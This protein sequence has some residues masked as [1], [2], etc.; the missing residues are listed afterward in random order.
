M[1]NNKVN[2]AV[3]D[4][5][6]SM[7]GQAAAR[8]QN[9]PRF[10]EVV[11]TAKRGVANWNDQDKELLMLLQDVPKLTGVWPYVCAVLNFVI[12][13]AGTMLSSCVETERKFNKTQ[14]LVG[15]MQFL[16]SVYI[17]GWLWSLYWSFLFIK[18]ALQDREAVKS[19]LTRTEV[20]S[21]GRV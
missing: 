20:R 3:I 9:D 11:S 6:F 12:S 21:D 5:G 18:R 16:T 7:G 1:D 8:I 15:F 19:F 2:D 10:Q 4:Q 14:L 13:G 17:I